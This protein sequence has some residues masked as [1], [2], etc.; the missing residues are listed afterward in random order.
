M[1]T[2]AVVEKGLDSF[3]ACDATFPSGNPFPRSPSRSLPANKSGMALR[4]ARH[5]GSLLGALLRAGGFARARAPM[6]N[7]ISRASLQAKGKTRPRP[8][9]MWFRFAGGNI[10]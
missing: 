7:P 1:Q 9:P 3:V 6:G 4:L 2:L 8:D 5:V 10:R